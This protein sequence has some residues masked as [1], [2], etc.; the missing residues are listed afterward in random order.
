MYSLVKQKPEKH[1]LKPMSESISF[2][3][4]TVSC[5]LFYLVIANTWLLYSFFFIISGVL[6]Y[7]NL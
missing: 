7:Y 3:V 2:I 1:V 4:T 6:M 5:K